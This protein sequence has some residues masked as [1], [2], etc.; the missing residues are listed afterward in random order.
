M[1]K[2][3]TIAIDAMGG[4]NAP[5]SVIAGLDIA[6]DYLVENRISLLIFGDVAKLNPLFEKYPRI[7][8]ISSVIHTDKVIQGD[9]KPS[10]MIRR[11]RGKDSSMWMAIDAVR[12]KQADAVVSGG[13]TGC[14]MAISWLLISTIEGIKRPAITTLLP[15][16]VDYT[17]MLDLGANAECD[18]YNLVQFAIMGSIYAKTL[19]GKERPKVGILN[20]GSEEHKGLGYLTK[21]QDIFLEEK[22]HLP[23]DYYGFVEGDDIMQNKVDVITT[24]G[25]SGNIALKSIEG[26]ARFIKS[27]LKKVF[28]KSIFSIIGYLFLYRAIKKF[29]S[30]I[31]PRKY[32]GAVMLGL[33]GVVVKSHGGTDALGFSNA[34]LYASKL[35]VND[36]IPKIKEE[37]KK[38]EEK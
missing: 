29:K 20:I 33:N 19:L 27:E 28:T 11:F 26:T 34:V 2:K 38:I 30:R 10:D 3:W 8:N 9:D 32:N 14:L 36:F 7:K 4:D 16:T 25:F 15:N 23:F 35:I 5:F 22:D 6:Y 31:D 13:N 18:E 17:A 24:D 37:I 1:E 21:A 12:N